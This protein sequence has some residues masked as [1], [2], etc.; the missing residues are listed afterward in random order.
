MNDDAK[1]KVTKV[2]KGAAALA[3]LVSAE[4]DVEHG[5]VQE[6]EVVGVPLFWR[7]PVT[8]RP[9]VLG[10]PFPRW[11]RGERGRKK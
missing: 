3:A 11:I 8:G 1:R 2:V 4:I 9:R 5:E 6:F 7:E 10:I